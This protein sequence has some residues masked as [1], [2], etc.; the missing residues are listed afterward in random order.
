MGKFLV[1][2]GR[3]PLSEQ[4][5]AQR[6]G[7][8]D[9][10]RAYS[11]VERTQW[12]DRHVSF[13]NQIISFHTTTPSQCTS[14][15]Y[16][17]GRYMLAY[18]G[19]V[20]NSAELR[21]ELEHTGYHFQTDQEAEVIAAS[22]DRWKESMP[23]KLRGMFAF[24]IL[25][26]K[27]NRLFAARDRLGKKPLYYRLVNNQLTFSTEIGAIEELPGFSRE[28]NHAVLGPYMKLSY[29][30]SPETIFAEIHKLPSGT[31]MSIDEALSSPAF[32]SYW[33]IVSLSHEISNNLITDFQRAKTVLNDALL[34]LIGV[35]TDHVEFSTFLSG[36][37][38]SSLVT[39]M[40]RR[41]TGRSFP[42][43]TIGFE[44]PQLNE[45]DAA[46]EI[47]RHLGTQHQTVMID[48]MTACRL[49]EEMPAIYGEPYADSSQIATTLVCRK[50]CEKTGVALTGDGGDEVFC[51]YPYYRWIRQAQIAE[52]VGKI[53]RTLTA[54]CPPLEKV[55]PRQVY[56]VLQNR[57]S[58]LKT[59][60]VTQETSDFLDSVLLHE[61][62]SPFVKIE[63]SMKIRDWV[64]RRQL[65]DIMNFSGP[66]QKIECPSS[67]CGLELR[68]PLLDH[69]IVELS[70]R[71]PRSFLYG[72]GKLKYLLKQ[73]AYDYIPKK[74]L[75]APKRGFCV[76]ESRW[77]QTVLKKRIL[78]YVSKDFLA[79]QDIFRYD[80]INSMVRVF[81]RQD[82][83][84]KQSLLAILYVS[85]L[86]GA[87]RTFLISPPQKKDTLNFPPPRHGKK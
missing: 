26:L 6:S 33:N 45:T 62:Y 10:K 57:D 50:A 14:L 66:A 54:L 34:A 20:Y 76:P 49:V 55:F 5:I 70:Q 23:E 78:S 67:V 2:V 83:T 73:T 36:G 17:D 18:D 43:F 69:K 51:G 58:D 80:G 47:A 11:A 71:F 16:L 68:S 15:F 87:P 75:D 8:S 41:V 1:D 53:L 7:V 56:F 81:G 35:M 27:K 37:I 74:F 42:T 46:K 79:A 39:A 21:S 64:Y 12:N 61:Y 72:G 24:V 28:I 4:W 30:P 29:I 84:F 31:C 13:V 44:D 63:R 25:D 77:L 60:L 40:A 22:Y 85:A 32:R 38:D 48:D 59:Q 65:I 9:A 3:H 52:P 86:V 82:R 19:D